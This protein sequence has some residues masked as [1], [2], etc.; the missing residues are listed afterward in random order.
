M[1]AARW[2][3]ARLVGTKKRLSGNITAPRWVAAVIAM[4]VASVLVPGWITMMLLL[5]SVESM[6][7]DLQA[8][9]TAI[10]RNQVCLLQELHVEPELRGPQTLQQFSAC[11]NSLP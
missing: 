11:P 8:A 9:I 3:V 6:S 10:E 5:E 4:M 1:T 7:N 2:L